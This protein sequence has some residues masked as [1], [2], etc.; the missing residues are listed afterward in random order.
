M[1]KQENINV[2]IPLSAGMLVISL[3]E[4]RGLI[5]TNPLPEWSKPWAIRTEWST[6]VSLA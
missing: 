4:F 2:M 5:E 6:F 3:F 1:F